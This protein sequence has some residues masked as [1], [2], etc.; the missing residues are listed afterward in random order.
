MRTYQ[1]A[2]FDLDGTLLNT[3][4]DLTNSVNFALSEM[5]YPKRSTKE[6]A[7]FVGNGVKMLMSRAVPP[8]TARSDFE[9]TYALFR[10]HYPENMN[11]KTQPYPEI[12]PMLAALKDM[13]I[14]V[15]IASNKFQTGV[16]ALSTQYF[17][18]LYIVAQGED[19]GIAPKPDP[20]I[21]CAVMK[22]LSAKATDTLFIGDSDVDGDT[23]KNFGLDFLGV[24]WGLRDKSVLL[25]HGAIAVVDSPAE[26]VR[27]FK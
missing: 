2:I 22:K 26:V 20:A 25:Q 9:K 24:G 18:N 11:N 13:G 12:L 5:K 21:I 4:D 1:Y 23:A 17:P 8:E 15:A 27:Y 14:G 19:E 16:E 10:Q 6:V 7:S 3:I